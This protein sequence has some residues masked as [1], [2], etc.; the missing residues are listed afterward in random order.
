MHHCKHILHTND[1]TGKHGKAN[2]TSKYSKGRST[3]TLKQICMESWKMP[4]L[5][6]ITHGYYITSYVLWK[7]RERRE[8]NSIS[9]KEKKNHVILR[10]YHQCK[11][12]ISHQRLAKRRSSS[13]YQIRSSVHVKWRLSVKMPTTPLKYRPVITLTILTSLRDSRVT[14]NSVRSGPFHSHSKHNI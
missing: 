13:S 6:F 4:N 14:M 7:K 5:Q 10:V 2:M 12:C 9:K 1:Y 8:N 3:L 11:T